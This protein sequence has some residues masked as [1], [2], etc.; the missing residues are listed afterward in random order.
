MCVLHAA[1]KKLFTLGFIKNTLIAT[2]STTPRS[3]QKS[4]FFHFSTATFITPRWSEKITF[5]PIADCYYVHYI[6]IMPKKCFPYSYYVHYA[7]ILKKKY[8]FTSALRLINHDHDKKN[9]FFSFQH[10][11]H[12]VLIT[13]ENTFIFISTTRSQ[14]DK[15]SGSIRI[16]QG[17]VFSPSGI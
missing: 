9:T 8:V 14:R 12:Y 10:Y 17:T 3:L 7:V 1:K 11:V 6:V 15:V 5:S 2:T 4:I 16:V 13:T